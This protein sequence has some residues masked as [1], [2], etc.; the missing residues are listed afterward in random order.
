MEAKKE[1]AK[2]IW[3]YLIEEQRFSLIIH[4]ITDSQQHLFL[5]STPSFPTV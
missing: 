2:Q 1:A 4:V 3:Y 5:T